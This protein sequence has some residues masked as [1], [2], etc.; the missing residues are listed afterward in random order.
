MTVK[1]K[2]IKEFECAIN[3]VLGDTADCEVKDNNLD[4]VSAGDI[5]LIANKVKFYLDK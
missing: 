2:L 1:E 4:N 5:E 3:A